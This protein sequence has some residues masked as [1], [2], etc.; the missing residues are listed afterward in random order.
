MHACSSAAQCSTAGVPKA[1]CIPLGNGTSACGVQCSSDAD[2]SGTNTRCVKRNGLQV[3]GTIDD[4]DA[5]STCTGNCLDS[6]VYRRC[7]PTQMGRDCEAGWVC[8]PNKGC[9]RVCSGATDKS[10]AAKDVNAAC[11]V[12]ADG[13]ACAIPCLVASDCPLAGTTCVQ[14]NGLSVCGAR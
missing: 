6:N 8:G 1:T 11:V 4:K 14:I 5:G 10:C 13:A 3:C 12:Y 7:D 2:C 9:V